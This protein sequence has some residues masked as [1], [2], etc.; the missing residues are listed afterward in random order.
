MR[1]SGYFDFTVRIFSQDGPESCLK[2]PVE[3]IEHE[4]SGESDQE[5]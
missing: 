3:E 4:C 5:V 1:I 2:L